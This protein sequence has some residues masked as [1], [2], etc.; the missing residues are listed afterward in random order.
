MPAANLRFYLDENMCRLRLPNNFRNVELT[1]LQLRDL[2]C[3]GDSDL[4][5]L[6]RARD[7]G[8][9][10]CTN[11]SDFLELANSGIE[12]TGIVFGEQDVVFIG[13]WVGF[14]AHD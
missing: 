6:R 13:A 14:L 12:H 11:D 3:L 8:R 1:Q 7:Q 4:R 10:I 5:H 9:V 2:E